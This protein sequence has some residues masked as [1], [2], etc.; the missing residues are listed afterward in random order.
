M[1]AP[2]GCR[3]YSVDGE[4][5]FCV[6]RS[7]AAFFTAFF[8]KAVFLQL[9]FARQLQQ[10]H[11]PSEL[12]QRSLG[13]WQPELTDVLRQKRTILKGVTAVQTDSQLQKTLLHFFFSVL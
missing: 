3:T 13:R 7:K 4:E 5:A 10:G 12:Q 2:R 1:S 11:G 8:T 9:E 6:L